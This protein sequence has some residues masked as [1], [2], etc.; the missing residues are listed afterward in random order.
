M[1]DTSFEM[2]SFSSHGVFS[3]AAITF[4]TI[5]VKFA[6]LQRISNAK[7][8]FKQVHT[9]RFLLAKEALRHLGEEFLGRAG[10]VEFRCHHAAARR[11]FFWSVAL[12]FG[13]RNR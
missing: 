2:S 3:T 12:D 11:E 9:F 13:E 4:H 7:K 1:P 6:T 10:R 8:A 5:V